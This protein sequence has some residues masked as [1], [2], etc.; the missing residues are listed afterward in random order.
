MKNRRGSAHREAPKAERGYVMLLVLTLILALLLA[1]LY[2]VRSAESDI[3]ASARFQRNE[4]LL[5][6]AEAGAAV[7]LSEVSLMTA[8]AALL[9]DANL[10]SSKAWTSWPPSTAAFTTL[11]AENE[12]FLQ[13][14]VSPARLIWS[15]KTPPPGVPVGTGTYIFDFQS[16]A[17]Y[18]DS[19]EV[20]SGEASVEVGFKTWDALP[21]SYAP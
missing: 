1:G 13:Y 3:R 17:T 18:A 15:G 8:P 2:G 21:G 19:T 10:A 14:R 4:I 12:E 6:A 7:R 16:F 5:R 11:A 9:D 20:A